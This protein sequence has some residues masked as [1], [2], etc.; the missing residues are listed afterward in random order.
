MWEECGTKNSKEKEIWSVRQVG[1]VL[2]EKNPRE[3]SADD[4]K[5]K[6]SMTC[7]YTWDADN[8]WGIEGL[9][10]GCKCGKLCVGCID[11]QVGAGTF[12][13]VPTFFH[14]SAVS[15]IWWPAGGQ[16]R[17]VCFGLCDCWSYVTFTIQW[18][19]VTH[20]NI[21]FWMFFY[22]SFYDLSFFM[23]F[24]TLA[25]SPPF[26]QYFICFC[27]Q[28]HIHRPSSCSSHTKSANS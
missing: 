3:T 15:T 24:V 8:S 22:N 17:R 20:Q 25:L 26:A 10:V 4:D 13:I 7:A 23:T 2:S 5:K 27:F 16:E 14:N 1:S 6:T 11:R 12:H 18:R 28:A 21:Q 19:C 9:V